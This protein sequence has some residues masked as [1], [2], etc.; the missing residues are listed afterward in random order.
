[1]N[2]K[3][4]KIVSLAFAGMLAVGVLAGCGSA[5]TTGSGNTSN[6][7]QEKS[8]KKVNIGYVNWAE[9]IAMTNLAKVVLEEKMGYEVDMKQ[10]EAGM[11]FTSLAGGD[12][13]VFMDGWLPLL[14]R[15]IWK[16]IRKI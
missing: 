11:V 5:K 6:S 15:I 10:G 3:L 9:G 2:K 7:T 4:K 14:I 1:M 12:M 8:N 16:N 13:D